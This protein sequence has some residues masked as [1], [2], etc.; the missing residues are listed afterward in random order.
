MPAKLRN[1]NM[2]GLMESPKTNDASNIIGR[3]Q[4]RA[5][6]HKR[7]EIVGIDPDGLNAL[8]RYIVVLA[9]IRRQDNRM[10]PKTPGRLNV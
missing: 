10:K 4:S 1:Y 6:V 5:Y 3:P 2:A 8:G 9:W 7:I